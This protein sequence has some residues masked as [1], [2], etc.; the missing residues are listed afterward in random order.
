MFK[1]IHSKEEKNSMLIWMLT[2]EFDGKITNFP[3]GYFKQKLKSVVKF[4][5]KREKFEKL[6]EEEKSANE[7]ERKVLRRERLAIVKEERKRMKEEGTYVSRRLDIVSADELSSLVEYTRYTC[8]ILGW[9]CEMFDESA[10][11]YL[12]FDHIVPIHGK[13]KLNKGSFCIGNIRPLCQVLNQTKKN[14][15][16]DELYRWL[17]LLLRNY[18]HNK[19]NHLF[20]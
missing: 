14:L 12:T 16:D 5:K 1:Q 20:F 19:M 2:G 9:T 17:I 10:F 8:G 18:Y 11:N 13:S 3:P 15:N 7:Q 6:S 4:M